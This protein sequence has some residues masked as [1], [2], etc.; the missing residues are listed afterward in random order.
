MTKK[1]LNKSIQ[2]REESAQGKSRKPQIHSLDPWQHIAPPVNPFDTQAHN[3]LQ[4]L[5]QYYQSPS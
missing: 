3:I 2:V 5:A 1:P 4:H